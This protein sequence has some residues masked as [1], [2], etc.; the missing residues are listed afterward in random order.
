MGRDAAGAEQ[1]LGSFHVHAGHEFEGFQIERRGG[2]AILVA[3][4]SCGAV[5]DVADAVFVRCPECA[6]D[7]AC[8]RCGGTALVID[9]TAL[10]WRLPTEKEE[11][12]ADGS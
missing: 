12:D 5:L 10:E 8:T 2:G 1:S 6:G 11:R 3:R 4:C 7:P 9:H